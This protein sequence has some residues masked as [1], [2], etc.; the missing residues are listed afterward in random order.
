MVAE[1]VVW[2]AELMVVLSVAVTV[3][4]TAAGSVAR[5][6]VWRAG[7]LAVARLSIVMH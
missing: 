1:L 3:A 7:L 5:T 2:K 6:V 4:K